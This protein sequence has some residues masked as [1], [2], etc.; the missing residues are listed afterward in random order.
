[1][2]N[3]INEYEKEY[4][5]VKRQLVQAKQNVEYAEPDF[6]Y[7]AG[8]QLAAAEERWNALRLK[9]GGDARC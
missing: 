4:L 6:M 2:P 8:L 1:M 9:M 3:L 7:A 5:E